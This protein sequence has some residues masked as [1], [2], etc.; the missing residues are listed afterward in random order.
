MK[1]GM[2]YNL[3]FPEPWS[4]EREYEFLWQVVEQITY[5]EEMGIEGLWLTEHHFEKGLV[6]SAPEV[7]LSAISQRTSKMRLGF[8]VLLS[9]IH[10]PL[11]VAAKVATLDLLSNG[12]VDLGIGR[13]SSPHQLAPFGVELEDTRGMMNEAIGMIPRM[14]T[15]DVFSHEGRY[16][17]VPPREVVPKPRQK[18]HPPIWAACNQEDTSRM[19]GEQGLGFITHGRAGP[20]RV[21]ALIDTYR[22]AIKNANPVGKFVH[23]R[24]AVDTLCFCDENGQRARQRG[25]E[26]ASEHQRENSTSFGRFWAGI[27]EDSVPEE[28]KHHYNR[29]RRSANQQSEITPESMLESGGY[30]VGNPDDC[31]EFI[32]KFEA[33]GIDEYVLTMQVGSVAHR[34]VM[35]TLRLFG[36]YV[37][38]HFQEKERRAQA[39]A[40]AVSADN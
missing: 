37:I 20:E 7:I 18:P 27:S 12:R 5:A 1:F 21:G 3:R 19:T 15:E 9:P 24:V 32:E 16:Y 40:Q 29:Y 6:A 23:D 39:T 10:H 14:W 35:N 33:L 26:A 38:P 30:C 28:Y 25:A 31:I 2:F 34:E 36:K 4:S 11:H 13:A 17:N 22:E 8:A